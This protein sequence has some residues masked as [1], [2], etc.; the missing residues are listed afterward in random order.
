MTSVRIFGLLFLSLSLL[1]GCEDS[2]TKVLQEIKDGNKTQIQRIRNCYMMFMEIND[3]KGPEDKDELIDFLL[4]DSEAIIRRGRMGIADDELEAMFVSDRDGKPFKIL[5]GMEGVADHAMVF[6][7][8]GVEGLRFVALGYPREVAK[9]EYEAYLA[10]KIKAATPSTNAP[11]ESEIP[12]R[13][14]PLD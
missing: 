6:E 1:S 5:W 2:R 7:E 4:T 3:Y 9:E 8:E 10:G 12:D 13:D 14:L 11:D